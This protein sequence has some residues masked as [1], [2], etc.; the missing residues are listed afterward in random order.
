MSTPR[1]MQAG[2]PQGSVLSPTLYNLYFNDTL[3]A[4]G[5]NLALLADDTCI[6]AT[7]RKEGYV[8]RKI[9]RGLDSMA[10][11]CKCWNIKINEDKTQAIYFTRRNRPPDSLLKL[12]GRNIPFV[13]SIKYLDVLFDKRMTW[14]LHI[15]MI[16]TKAFRTF[17][18]IYFL[19]ESE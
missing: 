10:A 19:F 8:L 4:P 18:R 13:N 7:D 2:V 17:I 11:W 15:Q 1:Y 9:Q 12:N 6:Y 5:V 14:R 16:E 3:Q